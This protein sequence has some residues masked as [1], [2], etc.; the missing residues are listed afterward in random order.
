MPLIAR[1]HGR[2]S[3]PGERDSNDVNQGTGFRTGQNTALSALRSQQDDRQRSLPQLPREA[4]GKYAHRAG[5]DTIERCVDRFARRTRRCPLLRRA[6]PVGAELR[7][8]TPAV[9]G[10]ADILP[11]STR[12]LVC[13]A[14]GT[15]ALPAHRIRTD[16]SAIS[17]SSSMCASRALAT[18]ST[19]C[20]RDCGARAH[21]AASEA[22]FIREDASFQ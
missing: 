1:I 16:C 12:L 18:I 2:I 17:A 15:P 8:R 6:F 4:A 13:V 10:N 20:L 21:A 9:A 22:R 19:V 14:S 7:R 5:A 11:A 3:A